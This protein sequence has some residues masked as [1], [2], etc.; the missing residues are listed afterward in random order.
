MNGTT[1]ELEQRAASTK[2]R[3]ETFTAQL[4]ALHEQVLLDEIKRLKRQLN[5][6]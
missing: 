4:D 2:A 3:F 1:E 6:S 5:L